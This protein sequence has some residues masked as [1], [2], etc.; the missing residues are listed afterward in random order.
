MRLLSVAAG[1]DLFRGRSESV[2]AYFTA[3]RFVGR[4]KELALLKERAGRARDTGR[5][6]SIFIT[7][8]SGAGKSRLMEEFRINSV[9]E[10]WR[11]L[12]AG[13]LRRAWTRFQTRVSTLKEAFG[14]LIPSVLSG[15]AQLWEQMRLAK[16]T[17]A[18][19]LGFLA[20]SCNSA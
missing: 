4:E 16:E 14:L 6:W 11:V 8:E 18:A 13:C 10:G 12:E 9:L 19:I 2:E 20:Q 5:G 17:L 7:G 1:H 15:A 3:G